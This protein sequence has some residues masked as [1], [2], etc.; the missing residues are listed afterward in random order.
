[1]ISRHSV[2]ETDSIGSNVTIHEFAVIRSGVTIGDGVVIH[3]SVVIE[4]GVELGEGVEVFPGALIGKEPKGA[5]ATSRSL[6]FERAVKI[7]R[8][9]SIGPN[10][11]VF[12]DVEIGS[13]TLLGD[14][15]S[16]RENCRIGSLCIISRY[17]TVN[18]NSVIGDRTKIMDL[19]HVTGN[20]TIGEDVFLSVGVTMVNDNAIGRLDYDAER[21]VGPVIENGAAVGAGAT[22]LPGVRIGERAIVGAGSVATRDVEPYT[23]V[24]GTPTAASQVAGPGSCK[25]IASEA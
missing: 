25:V 21:V 16:I 20:C 1:M 14:G 23:L 19:T 6:D 8:D 2:V 22:L 13:Q 5:G 10:S 24:I 17:V 3:P 15:A 12:Y 4:S 7:G 11:V 9:S 18:Y